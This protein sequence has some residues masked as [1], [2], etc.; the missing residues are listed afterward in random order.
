M[1]TRFAVL[2]DERK[3]LLGIDKNNIFESG[4]IYECE[5]IMDEIV[6]RKLGKYSLPPS[7]KKDI[8]NVGVCELSELQT[9]IYSG[10]HLVTENEL[11]Q[12][13]K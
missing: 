3:V 1:V 8:N 13:R 2:P 9:I 12:L 5:K 11:K 6:F 4:Y 10:L 7:A